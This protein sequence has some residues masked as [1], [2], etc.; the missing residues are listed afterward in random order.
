M[1]RLATGGVTDLDPTVGYV[2]VPGEEECFAH[3]AGGDL[4]TSITVPS[5]SWHLMTGVWPGERVSTVYVDA[6]LDLAHRRVLAAGRTGD[7][8][9][10]VTEELLGLL[11][12]A[13]HRTGTRAN[14][15][16]Q[17]L[18]ASAR[19]AIT[20]DHPAAAGLLGLANLLGASPYRLSRAFSR[21]LGVSLTRYRNRV[22]VGKVL[23]LLANGRTG[24]SAVAA[25]LGFTDQAHLC[26]TVRDHLGHTPTALRRLLGPESGRD[27]G[28]QVGEGVAQRQVDADGGVLVAP[29]LAVVDDHDRL[30]R[31]GGVPDEAETGH[32]GQ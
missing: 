20:T 11:G 30:A 6:R 17:A 18:V 7:V 28:H 5:A 10:A 16:E 29:G 24:L 21:Q 32:D 2:G 14:G 27:A 25:D 22:R 23:D 9:Y 3:P 26:R 4:C 15:D 8:D 1:S 12:I 31:L 13:L 19:E